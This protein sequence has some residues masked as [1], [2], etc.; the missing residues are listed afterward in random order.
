VNDE[1]LSAVEI[2]RPHRSM[3]R[4][5]ADE[6]NLITALVVLVCGLG[7]AGGQVPGF[8]DVV[9]ALGVGALLSAFGVVLL[10]WAARRVRWYYED[11]EDERIVAARGAEVRGRQGEPERI[12]AA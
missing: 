1:E 3:H 4:R 12:R 5:R 8:G 7:W 6:A 11:R 10:C 9:T 2:V